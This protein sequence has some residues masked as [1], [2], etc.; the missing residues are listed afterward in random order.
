MPQVTRRSFLAG[1]AALLGHGLAPSLAFGR[2][3]SDQEAGLALEYL[4][5]QPDAQ[6]WR[7]YAHALLMTNEF[8]MIDL[9]V[10]RMSPS[11][12]EFYDQL[13]TG[14]NQGDF[15]S[16]RP[17]TLPGNLRVSNNAETVLGYFGV[18][19]DT[20]LYL[21]ATQPEIRNRA[22]SGI[23]RRFDIVRQLRWNCCTCAANDGA[24]TERPA[25]WP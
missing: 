17:L 8:V 14:L 16:E 22:G 4:G 13:N 20:T 3:P 10:S 25:E 6:R 21:P 18:R 19:S 24:L 5:D 15:F 23:C 11:A 12:I 2:A 1:S 7:D 9:E